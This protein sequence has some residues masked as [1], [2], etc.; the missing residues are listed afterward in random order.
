MASTFIF[1]ID[2]HTLQV[3][4][5][6]FVPIYNY[7]TQSILVAIG[8]RYHVIVEADQP[9]G[10]YWIR[11][12]EA[13]CTDFAPKGLPGYNKTGILRYTDSQETPNSVGWHIDRDCTDEDWDLLKP[14]VPWQVGLPVN[15]E[16][17]ENLTVIFGDDPN[18]FPLAQ[19][20]LG[21]DEFNPMY[22][23]YSKPTFLNLKYSG[24][25]DPLLVL[26]KENNNTNANW[27]SATPKT[28]D[29][30]IELP[31]MVVSIRGH[32][33]SPNANQAFRL[34]SLSSKV[35]DTL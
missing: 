24:S 5:A 23:D 18:L 33:S 30:C 29:R 12:T 25:W 32:S 11:T 9:E 22:L 19:A 14:V 26:Y 35:R 3:V 31:A 21:G 10:D 20:S 7:S 2:N 1:S 28:D 8:Q 4:G 13:R 27:V 17:G 16:Y 15:G 34:I 6:D